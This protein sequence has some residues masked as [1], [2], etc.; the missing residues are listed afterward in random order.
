MPPRDEVVVPPPRLHGI[1]LQPRFTTASFHRS[2]LASPG[3]RELCATLCRSGGGTF[4]LKVRWYL[5]P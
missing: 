3:S 2:R 4:D 1:T 5:L